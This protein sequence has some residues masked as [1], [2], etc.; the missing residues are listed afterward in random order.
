MPKLTPD[1]VI[2]IRQLITE[3]QGHLDHAKE[4]LLESKEQTRIA[5]KLTN[6]GIAD[7]F[8]VSKAAI[9][10]IKEGENWAHLV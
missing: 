4:L 1:D 2:T 8:D 3:K 10:K 9:Q 7:M 6:Q 5:K